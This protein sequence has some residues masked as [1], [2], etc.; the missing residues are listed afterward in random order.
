MREFRRRHG[1]LERELRAQRPEPRAEFVE[2]LEATIRSR[3]LRRAPQAFRLGLAGAVTAGML[4]SL[5]AFGGLGYAATGVKHTVKAAVHAVAPA[6]KAKPSAPANAE[7]AQYFVTMCL[8]GATIK[9]DAN[10]QNAILSAGGTVGGCNGG[11]FSPAAAFKWMCF[12]GHNIRVPAKKATI[13]KLKK[14]GAKSGFC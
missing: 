5:A 1:G 14:A 4:V 3:P 8:K 6:H 2:S 7:R 11:A 12:K 13:K 9:I 10:A